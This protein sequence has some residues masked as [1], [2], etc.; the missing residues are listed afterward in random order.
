MWRRRFLALALLAALGA[1]QAQ[2]TTA[3]PDPEVAAALKASAAAHARWRNELD[4][5]D[6]AD[7]ER[8]PPQNGVL[9]VGSSTIRLW[10]HLAQDFPA[11]ASLV[12]QRG[13]GGSTL[14]ECALLANELV[15]R[16]RPRHVVVYAGDNDLVEGRT[17]LQ[18]LESFALL[19]RAVRAALPD[20]RISF[21]S[22]KPSPSRERWLPQVRE[23][24]NI[25]SAYV[26]T[27]SNSDYIDIYTPMLGA[28]GRPRP[29]LFAS[30]RLHMNSAG[31]ALWQSIISAQL[32][33]P[34]QVR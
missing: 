13:V 34:P 10:P 12:V 17:P 15:L 5:F 6:R 16:Y 19:T 20:T 1:A 2:P 28:D 30:D 23:A 29:E 3:S 9:F 11:Q 25:I 7:R 4:A 31:Y 14:A 21:V 26:N 33:A 24:N 8:P 32:M 18:I 27:L 22:I